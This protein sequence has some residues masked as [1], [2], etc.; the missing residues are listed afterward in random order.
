MQRRPFEVLV[1]KEMEMGQMME[2]NTGV[3][4]TAA[5][6]GSDA[7]HRAGLIDTTDVTASK[8]SGDRVG[9]VGPIESVCR[10]V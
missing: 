5:C 7:A 4:G 3:A 10:S 6:G 8:G 1:G 2:S 9:R